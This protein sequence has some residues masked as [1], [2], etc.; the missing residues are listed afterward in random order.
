MMCRYQ[1]RDEII[2][3]AS[4]L[5]SQANTFK[6]EEKLNVRKIRRQVSEIENILEIWQDKKISI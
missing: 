2:K 3:R 1:N 6:E 4:S 5:I